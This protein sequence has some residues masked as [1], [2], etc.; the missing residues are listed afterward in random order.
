MLE[1][2]LR[3]NGRIA[4]VTGAGRGLGQAM[5][6]AL[7]Q[8][9]AR[10]VCAARTREQIDDTV[11]Q[12]QES[13]GDAIAV[14]TDITDSSQV[15]ALVDECIQHYGRIDV[16]L[17]NAGGGGGRS[18]FWECSDEEFEQV[19]ATNLKG[20]FYCGRAASKFW[21]ENKYEGVIINV[22]SGTAMRGNRSFAYPTAKG[23]VIS[24]TKSEATMLG[25]HG[26]RANVIVPGFVSQRPPNS[27]REE[28]ERKQRGDRIVVGRLG[29]WW[30]LGPLAV[31][32]ASD[33]SAYVT[34]QSFIIDGGGLAG[35]LGP[36]QFKPNHQLQV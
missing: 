24:L 9:G 6:K 3:L 7:A 26:I 35:G 32:L 31:Y 27:E 22:S 33:A 13:G 30:E 12:I 23:G 10:I 19:L 1:E 20:N 2:S 4:V 34:G 25:P 11:K 29:E 28:Q 16:M 17:A 14:R 21:I 15:N 18:N 8:A 36:A 5:A